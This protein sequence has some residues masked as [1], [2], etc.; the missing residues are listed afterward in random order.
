MCE[1]GE[2]REFALTGSQ[3]RNLYTRL[4][5]LEE[6]LSHC[7][8]FFFLPLFFVLFFSNQTSKT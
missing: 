4:R 3:F 8:L 2:E 7:S 1:E 5:R 6:D